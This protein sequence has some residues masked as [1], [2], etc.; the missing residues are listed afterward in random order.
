MFHSTSLFWHIILYQW[1]IIPYQHLTAVFLFWFVW[2]CNILIIPFRLQNYIFSI[3]WP[4]D[5]ATFLLLQSQVVKKR[6]CLIRYPH[7]QHFIRQRTRPPLRREWVSCF[8]LFGRWQYPFRDT[9]DGNAAIPTLSLCAFRIFH[10]LMLA[11]PKYPTP[12]GAT[13]ICKNYHLQTRKLHFLC[14]LMTNNII[15]THLLHLFWHWLGQ[16]IHSLYKSK[17][18][19]FYHLFLFLHTCSSRRPHADNY[20]IF[21]VDTR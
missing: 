19:Y 14:N 13:P 16:N 8:T 15:K 4:K 18:Y 5:V 9:A 6:L 11:V 21:T 20:G 1:Y 12:L 10:G 2:V 3:N 17:E 7:G